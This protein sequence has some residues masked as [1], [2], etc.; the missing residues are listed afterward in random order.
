VE[1]R[2]IG[3]GG[4]M[5]QIKIIFQMKPED[6]NGK[7]NACILKLILLILSNIFRANV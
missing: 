6:S 1:L 2:L 7:V 5:T 4:K 3:L